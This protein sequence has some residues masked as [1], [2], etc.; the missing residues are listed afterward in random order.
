MSAKRDIYFIELAGL[1]G[2]G[3]TT[4]CKL[5]IERLGGGRLFFINKYNG[6]R[7]RILVS[8]PFVPLTVGKFHR[9]FSKLIQMKATRGRGL[10][11]VAM[12]SRSNPRIYSR[13]IL[14]ILSVLN[15]FMLEYWLATLEASVRRKWMILDGGFVQRGIAVWLRA[16]REIRAELWHA[17]LSHMPRAIVCIILQCGPAEALR[18]AKSRQDGVPDVLLRRPSSF[19]DE[20]WLMEEYGQMLKL[21]MSEALTARVKCIYVNAEMD[22]DK[23]ADS[24]L[25]ELEVIIPIK[26]LVVQ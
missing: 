1:P 5:L 12:C 21:L 18:R 15:V 9:I 25:A 20:N 13:T 22:A 11:Q 24:I 8:L 17:Y 14:S 26:D 10:A 4:I 3:K 7:H 19:T 2:S 23:I 6:W 16:P